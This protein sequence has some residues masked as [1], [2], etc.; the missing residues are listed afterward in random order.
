MFQPVSDKP[1]FP[2][3]E[4]RVLALWEQTTAFE[5]L[6]AKLQDSTKRFSFIDGP[7]TANNPMG[8]HHAWGRTYKDLYQR[9][10]AMTGH[11]Q[12]WQNGFDCQGLWV[13]VEVER[14]LG[15]KS[16]RDIESYGIDEFVL[17]CK[18]RVLKFARVITEQSIRLGQWMDWSDSY[19][20]MSDENN[21]TI[22]QM[23]KA[24]HD[25]G[26]I[27]RG[28]DV[29]PW[30]PR[31]SVGIS[32]MEIDTEG[33]QDTIHTS[34]Y[35]KF[36]LLDA[37]NESLLVWTTTPWTL[38]SNVAAA[39]HPELTYARVTKEGET[40]ILAEPLAHKLGDGWQ[41][42]Q[43]VRG[44]EL[45]DRP[46]RGP[47]D[48]L[49][50]QQ[51][52]AHRVIP[53]DDVS[54]DEGTG[55]VHIAPGC[56]EEDFQLGKE[57]K[58]A[59]IAP[60]DELGV[61]V[62]G[63]DWLTG[64]S[65]GDVAKPI[66]DNL[67]DK[68]VLFK[69][70]AYKHRYPH[71][72]R[73]RTELVFRLVDE[74]YIGVDGL[75]E[76]LMG[77]TRQIKWIPDFGLERELDWLRNMHDWMISKKRYWGLALPIWYCESCHKFDVIGGREELKERAIAG[78]DEFEGH[79][80]HRPWVDAVKI[81]CPGCGQ[82]IARIPDVGNPW[83]DAGI[84]PYSTLHYRTDQ[85]Y[86][87]RWF[88]ADFITE[89]FPG[90]YRNWFY[91]LLVMS[92]VL[93]YAAPFMTVLGHGTVRDDKGEAMHKSLGN[94]IAF[95][96]AAER[97]GAD[98][99]RWIFVLQNPAANLNFGWKLADETKRRLIKL[100]ES[101]KFFVLYSSL[102]D[103]HPSATEQG[104][105]TELDRW[106]Q[107]RLN[108]LIKTVRER[109]DDWD[110]MDA[111]RAVEGFF[112][113]LSNW[114]IRRSRARF[115]APGE[116]ADPAAMATLY[117]ALVTVTK[118]LAPFLPFLAED[119]YQNL[120]RGVDSAA[121]DS[122]HLTDYPE[123]SAQR[124]DAQLERQM[125]L[126][127]LIASLGNAARK[128]AS[129][130][131]RQPLQA[132]RVA[133]GSTFRELPDWATQLISDELNVKR[134]DY[135]RELSEAVRQ[136]AEAN[137]K[138]L[139]PKYGKDYPRIRAALQAGRFEVVD[140]RVHV[141]GF[142]LEPDEVTLSLEPAP[143]YAAAAERGVLVVLDTTL[144]PELE[145][146]GRAREVIR[147]IQDARKRAGFNVS[148]RIRVRYVASDG[149]ADAFEQHAAYIKRET[150]ATRLE[151][152]LDGVTDWPQ[153]EAEIDGVPVVVAVQ[154][155]RAS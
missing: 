101:Y 75:R 133:G 80:P 115:Q 17:R 59:V 131:L 77:V 76:M 146:E 6:R 68:G 54:Q 138:I 60:L 125:D 82:P 99:M 151:A 37:K 22:W 45:L 2:A 8:V 104:T 10:K 110:A 120:V 139:G 12:R 36:P 117:E 90:Q 152:G 3:L 18:E 32:Q 35:V 57:F 149:V 85:D 86:W 44:A 153:V 15:F 83:L 11:N 114:Y 124:E 61:Y 89:S 16:K 95:E 134:V 14:E 102:E 97:A 31:C 107:A 135:V 140:S 144:T 30:C 84:V 20:T 50:A 132:V 72:W 53:W 42:L 78:F 106:L 48:E 56:G 100:W 25:R 154:R 108:T 65:V 98:V 62:E 69:A 28:H 64:Q 70:E 4:Q 141:E 94:A 126:T 128:G 7:I 93:D 55:I 29:M 142:V 127:R 91:S 23:L 81:A 88:P 103:W 147:L 58:L 109:L 137:V 33:Y 112:E 148:D 105:P 87:R 145:A 34:V 5:Q 73:C 96:E 67:R 63:F 46:Y 43:H 9:Y 27:Y 113:D 66:V 118:L 111:A 129:I 41:V 51:G 21:Y 40:L 71:C 155:E 47:F 150:L 24:C 74:W 52:V 19:Y 13:E 130:P 122:V 123:A 1:D 26:W 39:V 79:S 38:T 49:P 136:R 116:R 143:G 92:T 119:L 121:P